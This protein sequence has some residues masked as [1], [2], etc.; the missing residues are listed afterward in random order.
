MSF[1]A[2]A[3][4]EKAS[5]GLSH[6]TEPPRQTTPAINTE[7][8]LAKP[9][10]TAVRPGKLALCWEVLEM[11]WTTADWVWICCSKMADRP[12]DVMAPLCMR[13]ACATRSHLKGRNEF[14]ARLCRQLVVED[15]TQPRNLNYWNVLLRLARIPQWTFQE[16][17]WLSS[18]KNI[19]NKFKLEK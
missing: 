1:A 19:V 3:A 16:N 12:V 14:S 17:I 11:N 10:M 15:L 6:V 9:I 8:T 7:Q 4:A 13:R 5:S 2:T 18:E